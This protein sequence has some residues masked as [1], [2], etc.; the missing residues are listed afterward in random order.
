M[1]GPNLPEPPTTS[2]DRDPQPS[3]LPDVNQSTSID[4]TS[5]EDEHK[6]FDQP[7]S[8]DQPDFFQPSP[9]ANDSTV[10]NQSTTPVID[11]DGMT[12]TPD[13]DEPAVPYTNRELTYS[14]RLRIPSRFSPE[15]QAEEILQEV[16]E[17]APFSSLMQEVLLFFSTHIKQQQTCSLFF[18]NPVIHC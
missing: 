7:E 16:S 12:I 10:I 1:V 6:S 11:L 13:P 14:P 9:S 5:S 4:R 15:K 3:P 2:I 8:P 18:L 17:L